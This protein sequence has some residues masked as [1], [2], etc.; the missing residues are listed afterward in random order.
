MPF[1]GESPEKRRARILTCRWTPKP[2]FS[3]RVN[4]LLTA[5]FVEPTQR[6]LLAD[7]QSSEFAQAY[8]MR[9]PSFVDPGKELLVPEESVLGVL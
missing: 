5:I 6:P 2:F 4:R 7:L 1:E 9:E 8:P 3:P